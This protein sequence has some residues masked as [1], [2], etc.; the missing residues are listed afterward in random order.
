M[1]PIVL[2]NT[3]QTVLG[4]KPDQVIISR[5]T[6]GRE[7]LIYFQILTILIDFFFLLVHLALPHD[8]TMPPMNKQESLHSNSEVYKMIQETKSVIIFKVTHRNCWQFVILAT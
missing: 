6:P 4:S 3:A 1:K 5:T 8:Q 7:R 2:D